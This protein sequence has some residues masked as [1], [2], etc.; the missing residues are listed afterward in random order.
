MRYWFALSLFGAFVFA[1]GQE[2]EERDA[3]FM[4]V[5]QVDVCDVSLHFNGNPASR[6]PWNMPF[7]CRGDGIYFFCYCLL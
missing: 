4:D 7:V 2:L 3:R 1:R 5:D 6:N